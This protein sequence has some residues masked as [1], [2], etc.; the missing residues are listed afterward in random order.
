MAESDNVVGSRKLNDIMN[1]PTCG[2][3]NPP[4]ALVCDCGYDFTS[5]SDARGW[6]IRLAWRQKMAAYW[7]ISW[8]ALIVFFVAVGIMGSRSS[9]LM[10]PSQLGTVTGTA[11]LVFFAAQAVLTFRLTRKKYR[12]FHIYI[13]R[14]NDEQSRSISWREAGLVWLCFFGVQLA[15]LIAL[16]LAVILLSGRV[17]P[18]ILGPIVNLEPFWRFFVVG[19]YAIG[20][21]MRIKYPGF[22]LQANGQRYI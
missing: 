6:D 21:G 14:D 5:S 18:A 1:C 22:R 12:T 17:S 8:P 4:A 2:L 10:S 7:S 9:T 19:P 20:L 13:V 11:Y 3:T 16:G 15:F